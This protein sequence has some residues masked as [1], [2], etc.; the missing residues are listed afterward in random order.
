MENGNG[1]FELVKGVYL[2]IMRKK[3]L[4]LQAPTGVGKTIATVCPAVTAM[5]EGITD[6]IFYLTAKTITRTVASE[7][8]RCICNEGV[9]LKSV[10]ITAK[11]KVCIFDHADCNPI[12]C[13]RA[14][15]HFDRIHD[16]LYDV[17]SNKDELTRED[18]EMFAEKHRVCPY[19]L[20]LDIS[21]WS[22]VIICEYNYGCDPTACLK[23]YFSE[24]SKGD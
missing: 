7:T 9:S 2:S 6:K 16:A 22:D 15:G 11:D 8:V 14:K 5:G 21:N 17:I 19:E 1:Q 13:E 18:I 10:V 12:I 20:S 23:R 4:F 3:K 24:K